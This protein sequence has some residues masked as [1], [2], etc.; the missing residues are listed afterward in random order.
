[1]VDSVNILRGNSAKNKIY[2]PGRLLTAFWVLHNDN[3]FPVKDWTTWYWEPGVSAFRENVK[4]I[5]V[6]TLVRTSSWCPL[7]IY[8][9]AFIEKSITRYL[10][11]AYLQRGLSKCKQWSCLFTKPG[12]LRVNLCGATQLKFLWFPWRSRLYLGSRQIRETNRLPWKLIYSAI[13]SL[14]N[15]AKVFANLTL[16][17]SL[18]FSI[19]VLRGSFWVDKM[20]TS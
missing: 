5:K 15:I 14:L 9:R 4:K 20:L 17:S 2:L 12:M 10:C 18:K 3:I 16:C 13:V 19:V 6:D 7:N 1:M 8:G 11:L